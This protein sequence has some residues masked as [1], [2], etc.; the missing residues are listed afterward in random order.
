MN[1]LCRFA[2]LRLTFPLIEFQNACVRFNGFHVMQMKMFDYVSSSSFFLSCWLRWMAA[3]PNNRFRFIER[4]EQETSETSATDVPKQIDIRIERRSPRFC[5]CYSTKYSQL[6]GGRVKC[7]SLSLSLF[8]CHA[9][10]SYEHTL[11]VST[12]PY[13]LVWLLSKTALL[14][15]C[16]RFFFP[17]WARRLTLCFSFRLFGLSS[18]FLSFRFG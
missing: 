15:L 16:A 2:V 3:N 12:R 17:L 5:F 10:V 7:F 6:V 18:T 8:W 14:L 1:L 9:I 13:E 4:R 11:C